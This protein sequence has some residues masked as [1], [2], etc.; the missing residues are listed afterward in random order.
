[1]R[2]RLSLPTVLTPAPQPLLPDNW[3]MLQ[4]YGQL[5]PA[6]D[7]QVPWATPP[8]AMAAWQKLLEAARVGEYLRMHVPHGTE[9]WQGQH[10]VGF[11]AQ[12]GLRWACQLHAPC[13]FALTRPAQQRKDQIR[14][15]PSGPWPRKPSCAS[16]PIV[17]VACLQ[18]AEYCQ[19]DSRPVSQ[20]NDPTATHD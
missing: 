14:S 2:L 13:G 18:M 3:V 6:F 11:V 8:M 5:G 19:N 12:C 15:D 10:M 7:W 20:P 9:P 16:R 17:L 1:M 4:H